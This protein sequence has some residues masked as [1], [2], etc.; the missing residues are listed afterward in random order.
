M[1]VATD[2]GER[3]LR[4]GPG[5]QGAA[6]KADFFSEVRVLGGEAQLV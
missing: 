1:E 4:L 2:E 5:L 6:R 3:V